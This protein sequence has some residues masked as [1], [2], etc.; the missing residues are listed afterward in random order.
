VARLAEISANGIS[1]V[2]KDE[3]TY[4]LRFNREAHSSAE[5]IRNLVNKLEVRDILVEE[6][7]I[8]DIVKRIYMSG[9]MG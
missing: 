5:V 2:R 3:L 7:P 9:E 1:C 6:E 8:E 4:V